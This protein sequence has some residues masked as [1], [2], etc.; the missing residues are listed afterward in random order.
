VSTE[1]QFVEPAVS[2]SK[3]DREIAE[4]R[5]LDV[6]Y[7]RR[8]WMLLKAEYP[9]VLVVLA[10]PQLTPP[11][12]VIGVRFDYSNYDV[13][14]PSVRLVNPFTAEPYKTK[15]IPTLLK[16]AVEAGWPQVPGLVVPP[17]AQVRMVAQQP[18][19]QSYGP[20]DIPFLCLAGVREYHDHPGHS[21]DAWELHRKSG[22]GRL[23]RLLGTITKYGVE[24]ISDY[25]VNL[26]PHVAGFVQ[27]D[28]PA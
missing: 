23:V 28:V 6:D 24:P 9:E 10:A 1:T 14:P 17:G 4:Y 3:F 15:D 16:R 22:A 26:V 20:E 8:G 12:I 13:R 11:A 27:R 2:R 5:M 19:M 18:L 7:R 21:G 25:Q